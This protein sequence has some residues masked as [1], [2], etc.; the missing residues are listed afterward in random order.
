MPR[1]YVS[2]AVVALSIGSL[3]LDASPDIGALY[4]KGRERIVSILR[5][6][7][8]VELATAVPACPGWTV[9]DVVSHLVGVV[10]DA[11]AGRLSGPPDEALTAEQVERHLAD[12]V[13]DLVANWSRLSPFFEAA[14]TERAIWPA[15]MD[16]LSHEQDIRGALDRPGARDEAALLLGARRLAMIEGLPVTIAITDDPEA[17]NAPSGA[18]VVRTTAFEVLRF[19]LGRRTC[20]QV[21]ALDWSSDPTAVIDQLFIFG[22][23]QRPIVE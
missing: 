14:L 15:L 3:P 12:P 2:S 20:A 21:L 1:R 5:S 10:E 23:A 8:P 6:C 16:V 9:H 18:L 19:R 22:P 13:D 7:G 17:Q 11:I 4:A